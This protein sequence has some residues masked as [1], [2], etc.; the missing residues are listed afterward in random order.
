VGS[1]MSKILVILATLS[2]MSRMSMFY[3]DCIIISE[4]G[5]WLS[6]IRM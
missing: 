6:R 4:I 3:F 1:L 5:S 2:F